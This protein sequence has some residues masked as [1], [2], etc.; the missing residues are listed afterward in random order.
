MLRHLKEHMVLYFSGV[1]VLLIIVGGFLKVDAPMLGMVAALALTFLILYREQR[2]NAQLRLQI[3]AQRVLRNQGGGR[4]FIVV[5]GLASECHQFKRL[6]PNS[7]EKPIL[8]VS[9]QGGLYFLQGVR[10][11]CVIELNKAHLVYNAPGMG[12]LRKILEMQKV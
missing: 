6:V 5:V 4:T 3:I 2:M 1:Y 8:Y 12:T 10:I 11:C 7:F 9:G